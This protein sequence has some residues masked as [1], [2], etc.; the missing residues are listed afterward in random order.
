MDPMDI[1][2]RIGKRIKDARK[3]RGVTQKELA[4]DL[5]IH[6]I[7]LSRYENAKNDIDVVAVYQVA[8]ALGEDP[9][10]LLTGE[11]FDQEHYMPPKIQD[12]LRIE[13]GEGG[14]VLELSGDVPITVRFR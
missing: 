1:Q 12:I 4:D 13:E 11:R 6:T 2:R 7:T 3:Q 10:Y 14:Y 9:I 8:E 5:S